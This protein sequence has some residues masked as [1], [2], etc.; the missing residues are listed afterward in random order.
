MNTDRASIEVVEYD[1]KYALETVKMWRASMEK[2]LGVKDSHTW[3][4]QLAYLAHLVEQYTVL[5]AIDEGEDKVVGQM[6]VGGTEL[7]QLYIHVDYQ[8][9]GIHRS[10]RRRHAGALSGQSTIIF[11]P[12]VTPPTQSVRWLVVATI[13]DHEA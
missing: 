11:Y 2:A 3:E 1:E 5:L 4:E 6:V 10:H 7:D 8:G 13:S 9:C 12:F